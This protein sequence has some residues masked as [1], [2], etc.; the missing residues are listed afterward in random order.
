MEKLVMVSSVG[1]W[2]TNGHETTSWTTEVGKEPKSSSGAKYWRKPFG[3]SPGKYVIGFYIPEHKI[4]FDLEPVGEPVG[5]LKH[6]YDDVLESVDTAKEALMKRHTIGLWSM[7]TID[8]VPQSLY[9]WTGDKLHC[10][11]GAYSKRPNVT[12]GTRQALS[13]LAKCTLVVRD[14][15]IEYIDEMQLAVVDL[16]CW[17]KYEVVER[18]PAGYYWSKH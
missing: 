12:K 10:C 1:N 18:I 6:K 8:L 2:E 16:S 5:E 9:M 14:E 15:T 7:F 11:I 17:S 3:Y 13:D 4:C